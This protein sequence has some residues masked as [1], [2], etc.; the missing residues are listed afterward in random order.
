[1][2]EEYNSFMANNT[3]TL[4]PLP[5]G[6]KSVSCKWV[7]KVKQGA[8]GEVECYKAKLMAR[9]FTETYGM[10]YNETFVPVAKFTSIHWRPWKTWRSIKWT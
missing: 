10:D 9:G 2:Q 1:M 6:R 4:V 3:W 5:V 7:F 8:N